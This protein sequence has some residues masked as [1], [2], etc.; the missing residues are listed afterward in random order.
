MP[1]AAPSGTELLSPIGSG[2]VFTVALVR[3]TGHTLVVKRLTPRV[4]AEPA[5][6]AAIARE[7]Q[8]LSLARHP[9]VPSL[10]GVGMDAEGPFVLETRM[11]GTSIRDIVDGWRRR[12]ATVPPY[13]VAHIAATT[14][15]ALADI[16]AL[17]DEEGPLELVH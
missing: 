2:S 15:A 14:S 12:E 7:A 3:R 13:L 11:T 16:H 10:K 4:R 1:Y 9:S 8:F 6:R 17:R 5:A